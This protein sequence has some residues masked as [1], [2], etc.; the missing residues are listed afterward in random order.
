M[1]DEPLIIEA[2]PKVNTRNKDYVRYVGD[3]EVMNIT[4]HFDLFLTNPLFTILFL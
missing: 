1:I 2:K 3:I 4:F